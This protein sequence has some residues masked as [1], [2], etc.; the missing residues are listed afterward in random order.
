MSAIVSNSEIIHYEV[1]GHGRPV[2]FL[3]GWA[4]SW[5]YW[6][7][8]MQTVAYEHRAYAF[9][10]WGF[11]DS[12][13]NQAYY[14]L[15]SQTDLLEDFVHQLGIIG[16]VALV[17]H[18][19]GG[20]IAIQYALRNREKVSKLM[21]VNCPANGNFNHRI[22][23]ETPM[24]LIDWVYPAEKD[25][26]AVSLE[27]QKADQQAIVRST[28]DFETL[29]VYGKL[30]SL[31]MPTLIVYGANDPLVPIPSDLQPE[32]FPPSMG[33]FVFN[34][35]GHYPMVDEDSQ[36]SRLLRQFL[37]LE[38]GISPRTLEIKT[39]WKRRVR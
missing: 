12:A 8:S 15:E 27:A 28:Q 9:D 29:S 35:S 10:F 16:Q 13:K 21:L 23:S 26:E 30:P 24:G 25:H 32:E 19:F 2:I 1:L 3:H 37:K 18:G 22:M 20:M 7:P 4:G 11:G 38:P 5:R 17:G 39:Q 14:G 31:L 6:V 34:D 36:F 33:V